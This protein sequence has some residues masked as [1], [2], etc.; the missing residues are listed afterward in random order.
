[1][2]RHRP[3]LPVILGALIVGTAATASAAT[4]Q[5]GPGQTYATIQETIA[6]LAPGDVVEVQG[7]HTYPGDL[8][9]R[10]DQSGAPGNP[11]TVRGIPVNGKLPI[12]QGVGTEQWHDMIVLLNA[13]HFVFENFEIVGDANPDHGGLVHKADDVTVRNVIV[14]G[15]GGQGLLGTDS[16]SGSMTLEACEFYNNGNG[17]YNHQVYMATDETMYP[18][19]IFRMQYCYIHDGA[20]GNN[21]KSRSERNEIYYNWIEGAFYHELDLIGPDG[22]DANLA[23]ED[24]DVVGNVLIKHSEWRIARIGGDGT[25]NTSGRYRFVNNTMV[26]GDASNVAIGLQQTVETVEMHNNVVVRVGGGGAQL[27][28]ISEQEGPD[29]VFFGSHNWIQDGITSI[30]ASFTGTLNGADPGF[31]NLAGFDVRLAAGAPLID[32]GASATSI[33]TPAF[34]NP[35]ALP[36]QVPPSRALGSHGPRP[37][38]SAIDIGAFEYGTGSVGGSGPGGSGGA[39]GAGGGGPAGSGGTSAAGG[40]GGAGASA[41]AAGSGAKGGASG[42]A[43]NGAAAPSSDDSGGCGCRTQSTAPASPAWLLLVGALAMLRRRRRA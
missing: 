9:F 29:P 41:G 33:A 25:G 37:A 34:V 26:L 1:M 12:I 8:W 18:G 16:D 11:V 3:C 28:N 42:A 43:G 17:M 38:D 14:H 10:Q 4:Y 39:S 2:L 21:V 40:S 24:S 6:L 22:Q 32:Q 7:D 31:I 15:V 5:V 23:R 35:L 30:P 13:S 19:S 20:G 27:W 36:T